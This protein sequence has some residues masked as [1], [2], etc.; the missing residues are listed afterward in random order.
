MAIHGVEPLAFLARSFHWKH[1]VFARAR[2]ITLLLNGSPTYLTRT[3]R[4]TLLASCSSSPVYL[5][6]P[7]S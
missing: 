3:T 2:N 1:Q 5:T 7:I 6:G 4:S